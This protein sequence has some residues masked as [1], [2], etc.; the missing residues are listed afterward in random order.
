MPNIADVSIVSRSQLGVEL[1][2]RASKP[3]L[4]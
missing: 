1:Q 4:L 2:P 3:L